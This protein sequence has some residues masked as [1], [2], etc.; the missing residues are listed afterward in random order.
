MFF[1]WEETVS[2]VEG[3]LNEMGLSLPPAPSPMANYVP[4]V[5]TG[6]LV[7]LSGHIPRNV[8][9]TVI[10]GRLGSNFSVD[11]GKEVAQKVTLALL[12]S[13]KQAVGDLDRISRVG[14]VSCMVNATDEFT[15]HPAVANGASD[16]LVSIFGDIGMHT[17]AATGMG[18]LPAGVPVEID[19]IVEI[20]D[21]PRFG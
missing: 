16:L 1:I 17:R 6:N 2:I 4:A 15:D 9:G 7:F 14:R 12:A 21:D 8:D 3:K 13:L 18:S 20:S 19:M 11:Q 5:I 10:T